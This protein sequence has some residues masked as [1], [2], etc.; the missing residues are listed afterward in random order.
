M[1]GG[2][3]A[4]SRIEQHLAEIKVEAVCAKRSARVRN[5]EQLVRSLAEIAALSDTCARLLA[6]VS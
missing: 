4:R 5:P 3:Q 2:F 1:K 6:Y